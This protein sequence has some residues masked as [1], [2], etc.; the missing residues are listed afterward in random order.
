MEGIGRMLV[1]F[2]SLADITELQKVYVWYFLVYVFIRRFVC[3]WPAESAHAIISIAQ[4]E[5]NQ[6]WYII[7]HY[8][9]RDHHLVKQKLPK[10]NT[11]Y[12]QFVTKHLTRAHTH[13]FSSSL[14]VVHLFRKNNLKI[15]YSWMC[16]QWLRY[17]LHHHYILVSIHTIYIHKYIYVW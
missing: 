5:D 3:F 1:G 16:E 10:L 9:V 7:F 12:P 11:S 15:I 4:F 17:I 2:A 13:T 6:R 14:I 8:Y